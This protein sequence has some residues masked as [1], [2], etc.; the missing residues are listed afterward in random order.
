MPKIIFC[1]VSKSKN[2]GEKICIMSAHYT[3]ALELDLH[4][5]N[6]NSMMTLQLNAK[7]APHFQKEFCESVN[8]PLVVRASR[9]KVTLAFSFSWWSL[10]TFFFISCSLIFISKEIIKFLRSFIYER[11]YDN[12][13]L[14]E[15]IG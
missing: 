9:L 10:Y 11:V 7:D 5:G 12:L 2:S 4:A 8:D 6:Q 13:E 14:A 1:E 3:F 15:K